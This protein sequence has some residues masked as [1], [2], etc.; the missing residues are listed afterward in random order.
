MVD[1]DQLRFSECCKTFL[2]VGS[3]S[4]RKKSTPQN[5]KSSN[6]K[7]ENKER[8]NLF[9]TFE[10]KVFLTF[11]WL[12]RNCLFACLSLSYKFVFVLIH[13]LPPFTTVSDCGHET[14]F[15]KTWYKNIASHTS[16]KNK[17][18]NHTLGVLTNIFNTDIISRHNV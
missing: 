6:A 9:L 14:T 17:S 3:F 13:F 12:Q 2:V 11:S 8:E 4:Y 5:N 10:L 18:L 15:V 16:W 7:C 1:L